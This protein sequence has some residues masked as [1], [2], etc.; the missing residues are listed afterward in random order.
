VCQAAFAEFL[1]LSLCDSSTHCYSVTLGFDD[2]TGKKSLSSKRGEEVSN[3]RNQLP[4][5]KEEDSDPEEQEEDVPSP[6]AKPATRG[7]AAAAATAS[8]GTSSRKAPDQTSNF[9]DPGSFAKKKAPA[10][11]KKPLYE[12]D[13]DISPMNSDLVRPT[14]FGDS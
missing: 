9:E 5:T 10:L 14:K 6:P 7:K 2:K 8:S 12:D 3:S 4:S 1:S 11:K 13:D